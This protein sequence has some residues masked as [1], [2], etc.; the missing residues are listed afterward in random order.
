[1]RRKMTITNNKNYTNNIRR[2]G[3]G[4]QLQNVIWDIIY[5]ELN[6]LNFYY[7]PFWSIDHNINKDPSHTE[8]L[9]QF[10]NLRN[11]YPPNNEK[12]SRLN[13]DKVYSFIQSNMSKVQKSDELKKIKKCFWEK[14]KKSFYSG[15]NVA[16][17]VRRQN[18]H[19]G[20]NWNPTRH[21][22]DNYVINLIE[23]I[24]KKYKEKD[25]VFH[26]YSLGKEENFKKFI[27]S[28]VILHLNEDLKDTFT[29]FVSADILCTSPSSFSYTAAMLSD[30]I[31]YF[32]RFWHQ[33][34]PSWICV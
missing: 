2:D 20:N 18:N 25:P 22:D 1:M 6:D 29:D 28:D 24:R 10:I 21:T 9:E 3:F 12:L 17:H 14:N 13:I 7:S 15:F 4:A 16:I 30:G 8:K 11:N 19:D 32:K 27:S 26:I 34:F 33:P 31:I 23:N 5:C